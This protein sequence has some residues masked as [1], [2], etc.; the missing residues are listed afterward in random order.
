[1]QILDRHIVQQRISSR[2]SSRIGWGNFLQGVRKKVETETRI[3]FHWNGIRFSEERHEI[4]LK[5]I[6]ERHTMNTQ[7]NTHYTLLFDK[8]Y[9]V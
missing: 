4:S 6:K 7:T 5:Y 8:H 9:N 2:I 3:L 1:M